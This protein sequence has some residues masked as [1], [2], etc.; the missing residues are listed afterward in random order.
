MPQKSCP[1]GKIFNPVSQRFVKVTGSIGKKLIAERKRQASEDLTNE[2]NHHRTLTPPDKDILLEKILQMSNNDYEPILL[3]NFS[4]MS[5]E[6]LAYIVHIGTGVK[7]NCY[8]V[9]TIYRIYENAI[10]SKTD[11]KDPMNPSYILNDSDIYEINRVMTLK[12]PSHKPPLYVEPRA[13]PRGWNLH[14]QAKNN[15]IGVFFHVKVR[16]NGVTKFDLGYIPGWVEVEHTGSADYTT[17]VL[18]ANIRD[19]WDAN[20]LLSDDLKTS[21]VEVGYHPFY[22]MEQQYIQKFIDLCEVVKALL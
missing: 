3:E 18:L 4:D 8:H 20:K 21:L 11:A 17:G 10:M 15:P 5:A 14:I 16:K 6:D 19:L 9:D 1:P 13:Y 7:K 22:W 2:S 12:D